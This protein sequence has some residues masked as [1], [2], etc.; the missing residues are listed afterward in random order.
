[1][2]FVDARIVALLGREA[3]TYG[4]ARKQEGWGLE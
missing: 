1:M 3:R 4:R 2:L